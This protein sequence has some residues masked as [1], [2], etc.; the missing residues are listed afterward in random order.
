MPV[1]RISPIAA[2]AQES[3]HGRTCGQARKLR[4]GARERDRELEWAVAARLDRGALPVLCVLERSPCDRAR[5]VATDLY[6]QPCDH[7]R[8]AILDQ[9]VRSVRYELG[10]GGPVRHP[11]LIQ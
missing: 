4:E 5:T 8:L 9:L 11:H 3:P 7:G 2:T 1:T 6:D 10:L